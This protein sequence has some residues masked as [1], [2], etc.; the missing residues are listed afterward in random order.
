MK[1]EC[2]IARDLMPLCMDEVAS[3]ASEKLVSQHVDECPD[4]AEYFNGM[5]TLPPQKDDKEQQA[6]QNAF[7]QA[8]AAL[9]KQKRRHTHRNIF[10]GIMIGIILFYGGFFGWD[11]L[12]KITANADLSSYN[13]FLSQLKDGRVV[14]SV[15][16]QGSFRYMM[17]DID[18]VLEGE[19][20]ILYV[21]ESRYL[22]PQNMFSPMQNGS[23]MTLSQDELQA[24]TEIRQG[25]QK[26]FLVIW[27]QGESIPAASDEMESYFFWWDCRNAFEEKFTYEMDGK[28]HTR[29]WEQMTKLDA[30]NLQVN[31]VQ[32]T[33]PEWQ[34]W[35]HGPA[36]TVDPEMHSWLLQTYPELPKVQEDQ[37]ASSH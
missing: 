31:A 30:I 28:V 27:K 24:Y 18:E 6:E 10:F 11:R 13:V 15:D 12:S 9:K 8:A 1:V 32:A 29:S 26:N 4:C 20:H 16:F 22:I 25:N 21:S 2:E 23:C 35:V 37:P 33:V 19:D 34:P 7:D 36:P 14:F 3:E 17:T 5:K